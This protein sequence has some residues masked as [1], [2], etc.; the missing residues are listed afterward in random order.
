MPLKITQ[1][2][3]TKQFIGGEIIKFK[4]N[5]V[6]QIY[7]QQGGTSKLVWQYD[8]NAP[9]L[10]YWP[11]SNPYWSYDNVTVTA[12]AS[13]SQSGLK[14]LTIGGWSTTSRTYTP[15]T[16]KQS[17]PIVATD[18]A[19]N[20]NTQYAYIQ[21]PTV[22]SGFSLTSTGWASANGGQGYSSLTGSA[23]Y[24]KTNTVSG[25]VN[26][27][28]HANTDSMEGRMRIQKGYNTFY[29]GFYNYYTRD[30]DDG[31]GPVPSIN[32][33]YPLTVEVWDLSLIHI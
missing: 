29:V 13:D 27:F 10:N 18:N 30:E 33:S 20:V 26:G 7:V 32:S 12:N 4:N 24:L 1:N 8:I 6:K 25:T 11:T 5:Q 19:G 22:P 28:Q 2:S 14:S 23:T 3:A 15:T 16:S 21:S 31:G 17:I 9:T